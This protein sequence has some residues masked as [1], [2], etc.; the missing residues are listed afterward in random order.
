MFRDAPDH[1]SE[2]SVG[3]YAVELAGAE[4]GAHQRD[5]AGGSVAAGEEVVLSP[6]GHGADGILD[7]IVVDQVVTVLHVGA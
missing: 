2:I 3:F 6:Y 5:M 7:Q 1:I 4:Q